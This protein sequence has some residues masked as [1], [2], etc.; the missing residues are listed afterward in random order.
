MR[1]ATPSDLRIVTA[2]KQTLVAA[3]R[4]THPLNAATDG[5][6]AVQIAARELMTAIREGWDAS[7]TIHAVE[8]CFSRGNMQAHF[9]L[10][11]LYLLMGVSD[12]DAAK[13]FILKSLRT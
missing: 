8:L 2:M 12:L 11:A 5:P 6:M 4:S 13:D 9:E 7:N 10:Q 1:L 3:M